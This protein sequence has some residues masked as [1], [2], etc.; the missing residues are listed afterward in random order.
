MKKIIRP[1]TIGAEAVC[2]QSD[3]QLPTGTIDLLSHIIEMM[4]RQAGTAMARHKLKGKIIRLNDS[5][6]A[7]IQTN[8]EYDADQRGFIFHV[9]IHLDKATRMIFHH[10]VRIT[11]DLVGAT[12]IVK[13]PVALP[14]CI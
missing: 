11:N 14:D 4:F 6:I 5:A 9:Y 3:R 8:F 2:I 13:A 1:V 10:L 12:F 7:S